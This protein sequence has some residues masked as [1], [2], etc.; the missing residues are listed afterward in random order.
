MRF[1]K[2]EGLSK[3]KAAI[4]DQSLV[5]IGMMGA[6]KTTIG[7][8][9]AKKMGYK[10]VDA[11]HEIEAAAGMKVPDIFEVF[12]EQAFRDGEK[13]VLDRLMREG[14]H[15]VATGGGAFLNEDTRRAISANGLSIWLRAELDVLMERVRRKGNRPLLL[16]GD[17]EGTMRKLL[18]ERVAVYALAD[19]VVESNDNSHDKVVAATIASLQAHFKGSDD[20]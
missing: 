18:E 14:P 9:L 15:I 4:G 13:K 12:G 19:I 20:A 7:R 5:L 11:D 6:G 3:L 16:T 17:P 1:F 8:R 10:F 2:D